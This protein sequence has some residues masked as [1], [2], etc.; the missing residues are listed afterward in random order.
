MGSNWI[1][2]KLAEIAILRN[3][4]GIKQQFFSESSIAIP[5]VKVSNFTSNSVDV[6]GLTKVDHEHAQKWIS[7]TLDVEDIVVATV[8]SWPPNWSSVVGKVVRIPQLAAGAI[9][10]QNTCSINPKDNMDKDFLYY[11]LK[12]DLFI[13]YV[14]NVAQGSANQA[15]VPVKKL[16]EFKFKAPFD[17][18]KQRQ[19]VNVLVNA[20][21]KI[22]LNQKTNQTL[23]QMAQAL[24]KS[25]FVDFDPVFDNLLA[26]VDFKLENLETSL[27]DELKQKAQR[28]LAALDS[29]KNAAQCKAS[30][31]ALAH[32]LQIQLPTK[33]ATQ[34][35]VQV[36]GKTAETP[37]KPNI[38]A[39]PNILA[40]HANTHAHFPNEFEHNEQLGWIPKGWSASSVEDEFA[41]KGGSTP[42]TKNPDFWEGG[43]IHWTSPKDLSG[44]TTKIMLDTSR[45]ITSAGLKKIT[46]GLLPID[47]V[48][49]SSR[50]P[51][52]YLALA[53]VPVAINQGYIAITDA[54]TL[55]SEYTIQW[56]DSVMDE[57]KG[58]SGGTTFAEISKKTFKGIQLVIPSKKAVEAYTEISKMYYKRITACVQEIN[59][60]TETRDYL[61]PKL[62]SGELQ[63]PDV[64]TDEEIVD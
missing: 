5:L 52:G 4:A 59:T 48:L 24:F 56:L 34:A 40:Q 11:V 15:R 26:S 41:V 6:N 22:E 17:I 20:D 1:E 61:L 23:E 60:L 35:A 50:A 55:S 10:N 14:I 49:M 47:T 3:G 29:L 28:R 2:Y 51:V 53:K 31:S 25:W 13:N 62:I 64:V 21:K 8:G 9:Q 18:E 43:E 45:K 32:E 38:N 27:P 33:E 54:Q 58:I 39:N 36:L 30:L 46:S 7:H 37:V 63:I 12:T 16:G 42:S 19:L 44:N 57:I